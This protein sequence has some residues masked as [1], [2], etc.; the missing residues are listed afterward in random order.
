MCKLHGIRLIKGIKIFKSMLKNQ[1]LLSQ[2]GVS[3]QVGLVLL[4]SYFGRILGE[5][6]QVK[7]KK[8]IAKVR[9]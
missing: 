4:N 7:F 2:L 6:L 3:S 8:K 9:Q 1:N 5:K